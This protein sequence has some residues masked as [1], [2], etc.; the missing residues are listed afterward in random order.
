MIRKS[1]HSI[2]F[3]QA[4]PVFSPNH[5]MGW[6]A[7]ICCLTRESKGVGTVPVR[8]PSDTCPAMA[9]LFKVYSCHPP[10]LNDQKFGQPETLRSKSHWFKN[11]KF[12]KHLQ[13]SKNPNVLLYRRMNSELKT[14]IKI[15]LTMAYLMT[16]PEN[17]FIDRP[18]ID[19]RIDENF[20]N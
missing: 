4:T 6:A 12:F 17:S 3:V 1:A 14:V 7:A 16:V 8:K 15:T 20:F 2:F 5:Y 9:S 18:V 19:Q 10:G 13:F 11:M